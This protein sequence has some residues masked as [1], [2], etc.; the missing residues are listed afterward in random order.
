MSQ[1]SREQLFRNRTAIFHLIFWLE[2]FI[3]ELFF[4]AN[5]WCMFDLWLWTYFL[6]KWLNFWLTMIWF[7]VPASIYFD[8]WNE[9][10]FLRALFKLLIRAEIAIWFLTCP[11][12]SENELN[13][14]FLQMIDVCLIYDCGLVELQMFEFWSSDEL[15]QY[16][17]EH[18]FRNR[19]DPCLH[20]ER[21]TEHKLELLFPRNYWPVILERSFERW[22]EPLFPPYC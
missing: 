22:F 17:R 4:P 2:L 15:I 3:N 10:V 12:S 1:Y 16:S 11:F 14:S 19:R 9:S 13:F 21:W 20:F 6:C 5:D 18:F 7:S 8:R